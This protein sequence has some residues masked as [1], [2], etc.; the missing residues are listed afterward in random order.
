MGDPKIEI[1][2]RTREGGHAYVRVRVNGQIMLETEHSD[3]NTTD[4][5]IGALAAAIGAV[6]EA[7][8]RKEK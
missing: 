4:A 6:A 7:R 5:M 1:T 3:H 8:T 2:A